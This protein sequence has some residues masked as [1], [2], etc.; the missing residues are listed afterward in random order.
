MHAARGI[1]HAVALLALLSGCGN[2]YFPDSAPSRTLVQLVLSPASLVLAPGETQQFTVSGTR[3][4][5]SGT[6]P[7]VTYSATGG[8]ITAGGLYTA[9]A[10]EGTF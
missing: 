10:T 5:G 1:L 8:T 4:D 6:V 9:G 7:A 2:R 3:S